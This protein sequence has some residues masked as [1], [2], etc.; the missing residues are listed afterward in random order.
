MDHTAYKLIG[1]YPY[2]IN[3][4]VGAVGV[5]VGNRSGSD[6]ESE[7]GFPR[8]DQRAQWPQFQKRC[9][10]NWKGDIPMTKSLSS[11]D[12]NRSDPILLTGCPATQRF[13]VDGRY[14]HH[15]LAIKPICGQPHGRVSLL[16]G[17]AFEPSRILLAENDAERL[18]KNIDYLISMASLVN[19]NNCEFPMNGVK[20]GEE[21]DHKH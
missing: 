3:L 8:P 15:C 9:H 12:R 13:D 18:P 2:T 7:T 17:P 1:N 5:R 21:L 4:E 10:W 20:D 6:S 14:S 19:L 11:T 16:V